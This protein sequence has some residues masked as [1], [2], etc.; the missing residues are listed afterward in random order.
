MIRPVSA[1]GRIETGGA[2]TPIR[3]PRVIERIAS[4]AASRIVLII[5]PA[6][7][8]K[9]V[10]LRQYLETLPEGSFVRYD[11]HPENGSLLGFV[12]GLADALIDVAPAARKTVSGAYEKSA[13]S[14]TPGSDLAMWMHAHVKAYT[15]T[16]AID[17]LHVAE[18]DPEV[19]RFLASLVERTKGRT[20]WIVASRS[21]LD[22]PV[23]SWLAY[24]ES[25]LHVDERDL[26]FTLEEARETAKSVR[27]AVRDEE[28]NEI[29][30][31]TEGWPTALSFALRTSTRSVDL[32]NIAA[33][34]REMVYR[35]LAEQ[36]YASLA[37]EQRALLHL[38]GMLP[39]IDLEVVRVAGFASTKATVEALRD[40]V[41]FIYPERPGVYRCH[42][43]FREFLQHELELQGEEAVRRVQMQAA[44]ALERSRHVA[45]ALALYTRAGAQSDVLRVISHSGFDL[46]EQAHTD[47]VH[48]ALD[49]LSA[50]IRSSHP[51]VLGLR[52]LRAADMGRFDRAESLLQRAIAG[53]SQ[54]HQLR[55][56]LSERLG[57]LLFNQ[58]K[59][60]IGVLEAA[61]LDGISDTVRGEILGL[62][63]VAYAYDGRHELARDA[64]DDAT[65]LA[66][67][68]ESEEA[69]AR[70]LHRAGMASVALDLPLADVTTIFTQA[71]ALATQRSM[72]GL[73]ALSL[74]GL[75]NI[76]LLY[77]DDMTKYVWYA[78]QAANAA[79]KAGD[80]FSMQNALL[81]LIHAET[82]RGNAE[83]VNALEIQLA[84][85]ATTDASR[86]M[87]LMPARAMRAAWRGEF[88]EAHRLLAGTAEKSFYAFDRVFN[89]SMEALCGIAAGRRAASL[90]LAQKTI[91]DIEA[92]D[93]QYLH[94]E[95]MAEF[96]RLI[97]AIVEAC[98][99]RNVNA[100][101][102]M[103][104]KAIGSGAQTEA[105]REVASAVCRMAKN[106]LLRPEVE[107][108]LSQ[109][110]T[111]GLAG[112]ADTTHR[113]IEACFAD[114]TMVDVP[115]TRAEIDILRALAEGRTPKSIAAE[116]G[117]SY[118][119]VRMHVKNAIRKLGCS[120]RTEALS[121]AR[122][123]GLIA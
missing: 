105:M 5:A 120:G 122:K 96:A 23:G 78:Q 81:Q 41:S 111:V 46:I 29:L 40:R 33:T 80:R 79:M 26:M 12:R 67:S 9:S 18:A 62:L 107:D 123:R 6:G 57:V 14:S 92:T 72:F 34:T 48:A 100:N 20:R 73:A 52:G 109:L 35:F 47:V 17:D 11:V 44:G 16:I 65:D 38:I 103:Q 42:D 63:A 3:R 99:G 97:C 70:I 77:E 95:R 113:A 4:A 25:D 76:A 36:V 1:D 85:V 43:L 119:T 91:A 27:V 28:L 64:L 10:A 86:L 56:E 112:I 60:V 54:D 15:G 32:R 117:R 24:G 108:A 45:Q 114:Q 61:L 74:G 110:R 21:S 116:T 84:A 39:E 106:T 102:I 115:L 93:F 83:R 68:I 37:P 87:I 53:C 51:L 121:V 104:R 101:R 89:A 71:Q 90:A 94:G 2:F 98:A 31:M 69:R 22:L 55:A 118:E 13:S 59:T 19:S 30:T 88:E 58:R 66:A 50:D 7:Y 82:M 49:V 75:A 8:G